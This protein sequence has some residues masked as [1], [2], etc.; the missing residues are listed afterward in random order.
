MGGHGSRR[1]DH[2]FLVCYMP[3]ALARAPC[4]LLASGYKLLLEVAI[5][6]ST[7]PSNSYRITTGENE[8]LQLAQQDCQLVQRSAQRAAQPLR[9]V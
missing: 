7:L 9:E 8:L 3:L 1:R 4:I 2:G 6:Y 5:V